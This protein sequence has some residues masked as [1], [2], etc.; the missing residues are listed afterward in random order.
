MKELGRDWVKGKE[1]DRGDQGVQCIQK[2]SSFSYSAPSCK[3]ADSSE[4]LIQNIKYLPKWKIVRKKSETV[5]G[6]CRMEY[7]RVCWTLCAFLQLSK[8]KAEGWEINSCPWV[9]QVGCPGHGGC[10]HMQEG[11]MWEAWEGH[12]VARVGDHATE[13]NHSSEER[14][15]GGLCLLLLQVLL[16]FPTA[17]YSSQHGTITGWASKQQHRW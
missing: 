6:C 12:P 15:A 9:K 3:T 8:R 13:P 14:G 10:A 5:F 17:L 11:G 1:G 16:G 2:C 4:M 7:R